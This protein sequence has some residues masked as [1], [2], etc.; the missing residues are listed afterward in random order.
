MKSSKRMRSKA[1][2]SKLRRKRSSKRSKAMRSKLSRKRSIKRSSKQS[3]KL[4]RGG[5]PV[6]DFFTSPDSHV[7]DMQL[8][9]IDVDGN[10][11]TFFETDLDELPSAEKAAAIRLG[12]N[13]EDKEET[14]LR[15][16]YTTW[17]QSTI[18]V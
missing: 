1:M 4:M 5:K 2:R 18:M 12:L 3:R 17:W 14:K 8:L 16:K 10:R 9:N 11:S 15:G 13:T 6:P 7:A